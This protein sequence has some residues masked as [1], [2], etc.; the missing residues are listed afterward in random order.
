MGAEVAADGVL[1]H[2]HWVHSR[3]AVPSGAIA[4]GMAASAVAWRLLHNT[5]LF[6][7]FTCE[8]L[9]KRARDGVWQR[10]HALYP[11][12]DRGAA[13]DRLELARDLAGALVLRKRA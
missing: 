3:R 4:I 8:V 9:V 1:R 12:A 2:H 13:T 7:E 6:A 10:A 11:E 5:A